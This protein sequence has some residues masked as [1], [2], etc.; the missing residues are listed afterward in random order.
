MAGS[1]C[2]P[3]GFRSPS[4]AAAPPNKPSSA[5]ATYAS[6]A[7]PRATPSATPTAQKA[8]STPTPPATSACPKGINNIYGDTYDAIGKP[9]RYQAGTIKIDRTAPNSGSISGIGEGELARDQNYTISGSSTDLLSGSRTVEIT[10]DGAQKARR[11]NCAGTTSACSLSWNLDGR[12]QTLTEGTHTLRVNA[13]DQVGNS[14]TVAT[15][16]FRVDRTPPTG[17]ISGVT[18]GE[19]LRDRN[20]TITA[21]TTDGLS[22]SRNIQITL[23]NV[24]KA[25]RD[26]CPATTNPCSLEWTLDGGDQ[27]LTEGTHTLRVNATDQAGNGPATVATR[28]FKVDRTKPTFILEGSLLPTDTGWVA[29]G[30]QDLNVDA[31]D[32]GGLVPPTG[33]TYIEAKVD[34]TPIGPPVDQAC[35]GGACS[36]EGEFLTSTNTLEPGSHT[37][38]V[39]VR[40][41]AGNVADAEPIPFKVERDPPALALGGTLHAAR[42]VTL[43]E[44]GTYVLTATAT[45]SAISEQSGMGRIDVAV[46]DD[47]PDSVDSFCE[48]GGCPMSRTYEYK[49]NDYEPGPHTVTVTAT[50][51]AGNETRET[52]TVGNPEPPSPDCGPAPMPERQLGTVPTLPALA[53]TS[54]RNQLP[55]AFELWRR[56]ELGETV[57]QP[58]LIDEGST[59]TSAQSLTRLIVDKEATDGATVK[60][61]TD[62]APICMTPA[63]VSD[64]ASQPSTVLGDASVLYVN[65][66]RSTDAV[67]RAT[68]SGFE[69]FH[70]LR[71]PTA[72]T[73]FGWTFDLQPGQELKKL[74]GGAVA[75]VKPLPGQPPSP[76]DGVPGPPSVSEQR[77][78]ITNTELQLEQATESLER[79]L[80]STGDEIIAVIPEPWA[81]DAAGRPIETS[82]EVAGSK[83]TMNV[84]H[85]AL[86][87]A[88]PVV[89]DPQVIIADSL[90]EWE[91]V[92]ADANTADYT[93]EEAEEMELSYTPEDPAPHAPVEAVGPPALDDGD[94][95]ATQVETPGPMDGRVQVAEA[96]AAGSRRRVPRIGLSESQPALFYSPDRNDLAPAYYRPIVPWNV[97]QLLQQPEG[98][99]LKERADLWESWYELTRP[100]GTRTPTEAPENPGIDSDIAIQFE[101]G[102][103]TRDARP[104]RVVEYRKRLDGFL[105]RYGDVVDNLSP[106][107]EP[108]LG[109]SLEGERISPTRNNPFRAARYWV[110]AQ[111]LCH[112]A[113]KPPR[114]RHVIAGEYSGQKG[115]DRYK[116]K[117][118]DAVEREQE[119]TGHYQDEYAEYLHD[120]RQKP[121]VWGYHAYNDTYRGALRPNATDTPTSEYYYRKFT[122]P[123]YGSPKIWLT[124]VGSYYHRPCE[125]LTPEFQARCT[126][127]EGDPPQRIGIREQDLLVGMERQKEGVRK[128]LRRIGTRKLGATSDGALI[129]RFY[130]HRL[131]LVR[132][133]SVFYGGPPTVLGPGCCDRKDWGLVG[134]END[135]V[136]PSRRGV[137]QLPPP[138][139]Q[140]PD[141]RDLSGRNERRL[142]YCVLRTASRDRRLQNYVTPPPPAQG[143]PEPPRPCAR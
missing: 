129:N 119:K 55:E 127:Q 33:V 132:D 5:T 22:G 93:Y 72:P 41:G 68:A 65:S 17:S 99:E 134:T 115:G 27:A 125:T 10:L 106:W 49:V 118:A 15:R 32:K 23:D 43:D 70:Q 140:Q 3:T 51:I 25:R 96:N 52:F 7:A 76:P 124:A 120:K 110:V 87:T 114:C 8:T 138:G 105:R 14:R 74:S 61:Y 58:R 131:Q 40:D 91:A 97:R 80:Q 92:R 85:D 54:F 48:D 44:D 89:T 111:H 2:S 59:F 19:L 24:E 113:N 11:D 69:T 39:V 137:N 63:E 112:Q 117:Y 6:L 1:G 98:S 38:Q 62:F 66:A 21:T 30:E 47:G 75:V 104:P 88:Y 56:N 100:N 142:V 126:A 139:M 16:S 31:S 18:E 123:E 78:A 84:V 13:T 103:D 4:R 34:G 79:A 9:T 122:E 141:P 133:A 50:D 60:A 45:D 67:V 86:G 20:Y 42:G 12:D 94:P 71:D 136:Y 57:L 73:S 37:L 109:R 101:P 107:N 46:D 143:Q 26:D 29:R 28:T 130:Y 135:D 95:S 82:L 36:L 35:E 128:L 108:N 90:D 83:L 64:Q 121:Q 53:E 81:V 116:L 77:E 102:R